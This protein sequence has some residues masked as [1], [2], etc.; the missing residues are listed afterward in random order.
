M[1]LKVAFQGNIIFH[2]NLAM[3]WPTLVLDPV[4]DPYQIAM[5]FIGRVKV[6][7]L[8]GGILNSFF[9][10]IIIVRWSPDN[11]D[12]VVMMMQCGATT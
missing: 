3:G 11:Q 12:S 4:H 9:N 1:N 5:H 2:L 7:W 8:H 6:H 10:N